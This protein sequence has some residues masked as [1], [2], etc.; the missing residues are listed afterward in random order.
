MTDYPSSLPAP[1]IEGFMATVSMGV[2]RSDAPGHQAQRR[3]FS[4]MPHGFS[5]SFIMSISQWGSWSQWVGVN[6][7]RWFTMDLPTLYAGRAGAKVLPV[8]IRF[9]SDVSAVNVSASSVRAS[10]QAET[11]PSF[12]SAYLDAT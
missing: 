12:I 8:T 11:A 3:V 1:L 9:V 10:V 4:T 6:G 7:Y 2:I 5:L